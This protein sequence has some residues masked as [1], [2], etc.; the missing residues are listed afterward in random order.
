MEPR[1]QK[2][3][4]ALFKNQYQSRD[5]LLSPK[6]AIIRHV[7]A[8]AIPMSTI[9]KAKTIVNFHTAVDNVAT[10]THT[11][12]GY[13]RVLV[14]SRARVQTGQRSDIARVKIAGNVTKC[15]MFSVIFETPK[16]I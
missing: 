7:T 5:A 13:C 6:H 14:P 15:R 10:E 16:I 11:L 8:R 12:A 4:Y 2:Q 3:L 1:S 9:V